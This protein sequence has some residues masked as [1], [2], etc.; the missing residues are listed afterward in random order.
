M[1]VV[2][3]AGADN[4][5]LTE[6]EV[7]GDRFGDVQ[8]TAILSEQK[9]EA[10]QWL[11]DVLPL[12]RVECMTYLK[13]GNQSS[14]ISERAHVKRLDKQIARRGIGFVRKLQADF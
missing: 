6:A 14:G 5:G 7:D 4:F 13:L 8:K 3:N 12:L 2:E 1:T 10:V 9:H 11:E